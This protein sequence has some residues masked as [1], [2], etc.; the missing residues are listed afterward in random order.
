M[1]T[2]QRCPWKS[3]ILQGA[4]GTAAPPTARAAG[5]GGG[6]GQVVFLYTKAWRSSSSQGPTPPYVTV[7]I[8]GA[9]PALEPPLGAA[10]SMS[11]EKSARMLALPSH[12]ATLPAAHTVPALPSEKANDQPSPVRGE[13]WSEK[14]V[15]LAQKM[16]VGPRIPV[17]VQLKRLELA[18][19]LGQLGVFLTWMRP[20][21]RPWQQPA[22]SGA[23]TWCS[24]CAFG[25]NL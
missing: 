20:P 6:R 17:G 4:A 23:S 11:T 3:S 19:L 8:V 18:Q 1:P 14:G 10:T 24:P 9:E 22:H 15:R 12:P 21:V 7:V 5:G 2:W 13:P 25:P 16:R